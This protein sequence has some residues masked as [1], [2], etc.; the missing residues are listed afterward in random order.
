V[1]QKFVASSTAVEHLVPFSNL[2]AVLS[3]SVYDYKTLEYCKGRK[4]II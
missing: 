3:K 4:M 1:K 2:F